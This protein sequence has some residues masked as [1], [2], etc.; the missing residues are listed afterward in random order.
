MKLKDAI[1]DSIEGLDNEALV[2]LYEQ[3][4]QIQRIKEPHQDSVRA[5]A[6]ALEEVLRLTDDNP[7][8]WSADIIAD[9][10]ERG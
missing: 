6:P 4:Q 7:D 9:R 8:P 1:C 5:P 10:A 2:L 3:I